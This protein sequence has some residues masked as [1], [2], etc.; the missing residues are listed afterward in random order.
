MGDEAAPASPS[1]HRR[2]ATRG[3]I[4]LRR[5]KS[6]CPLRLSRTL[7]QASQCHSNRLFGRR[8]H[9]T[10]VGS[11]FVTATVRRAGGASITW[12]VGWGSGSGLP[13]RG[14]Q[15]LGVCRFRRDPGYRRAPGGPRVQPGWSTTPA[16][17]CGGLAQ[18]DGGP[19]FGRVGTTPCARA[20]RGW[21]RRVGGRPRPAPAAGGCG[22]PLLSRFP[23]NLKECEGGG[24][25]VQANR[26]RDASAARRT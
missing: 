6:T 19:G 1:R 12:P 24:E 7:G 5:R 17:L 23:K 16:M 25:S 3:D 26:G 2:R 22:R 8:G 15:G 20:K 21:S 10:Q 14:Q 18:T 11:G 4:G 13:G 9:R